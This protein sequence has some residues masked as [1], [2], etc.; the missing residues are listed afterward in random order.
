[1]KDSFNAPIVATRLEQRFCAPGF[2]IGTGDDRPGLGRGFAL[3]N[4][5]TLELANLGGADKADLLRVSVLEPQLASFLPAA[6]DLLPLRD[7]RRVLRE[8]RRGPQEV[9]SRFYE[10]F[11]GWF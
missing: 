3:V 11:P 7:L 1:V 9:R 6:I 2:G 10:E 5:P 8:K 4:G